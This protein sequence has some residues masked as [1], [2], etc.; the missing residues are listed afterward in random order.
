MCRYYEY[1]R[2]YLPCTVLPC[3]HTAAY[4]QGVRHSMYCA[5]S[6]EWGLFGRNT[7]S[8]F[9]RT[10][11]R[12]Y[13]HPTQPKYN[14]ISPK[15]ELF[16][17]FVC[18]CAFFVVL[19]TPPVGKQFLSRYARTNF[20]TFPRNYGRTMQPILQTLVLFQKSVCPVIPPYCLLASELTVSNKA[21]WDRFIYHFWKKTHFTC[22]CAFFV[23][24][25]RD[26]WRFVF[27]TQES[28]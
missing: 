6:S 15:S 1:G 14:Q 12:S 19:R 8:A 20:P 5:I 17:R 26:F 28:H 22:V 21:E 23:V 4:P 11:S 9:R 25:L 18:I 7:R 10:P 27:Y 24:T 13:C 2:S 16:A 3:S